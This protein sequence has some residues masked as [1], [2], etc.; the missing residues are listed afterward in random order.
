MLGERQ[1]EAGEKPTEEPA[2][3]SPIVHALHE[4]PEGEEHEGPLSILPQ[5][6]AA[7]D[8]AALATERHDGPE[9]AEDR[10][11]GADRERNTDP[12][13]D[14]EPGDA[15]DRE[16]HNQAR[17]PVDLLDLRPELADPQDVE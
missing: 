13:R 8:S 17:G 1:R 7:E 9:Q 4:E 3:V 2:A 12:V 5:H 11:G 10:A 16:D 15:G 14:D 6:H